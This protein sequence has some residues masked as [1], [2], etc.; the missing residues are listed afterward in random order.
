M[1]L[2]VSVYLSLSLSVSLSTYVHI[3][4]ICVSVYLCAYKGAHSDICVAM[5]FSSSV[6]LK[7]EDLV[8]ETDTLTLNPK[9]LNALLWGL[10][11]V[12]IM[13]YCLQAGAYLRLQRLWETFVAALHSFA[14]CSLL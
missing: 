7:V 12:N 9:P 14:M 11:I 8:S 2:S 10:S 13:L 4:P 5:A 3:H 6:S 1:C